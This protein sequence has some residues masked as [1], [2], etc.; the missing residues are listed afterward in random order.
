MPAFHR[1]ASLPHRAYRAMTLGADAAVAGM[2]NRLIVSACIQ[3]R[4]VDHVAD[5]D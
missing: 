4:R 2:R 5:A 3:V 1:Q